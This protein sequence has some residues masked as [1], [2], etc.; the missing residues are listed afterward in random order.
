[1]LSKT[2]K[3][4]VIKDLAEKF[5][6]KKIAIF[7]DFHGISVKKLQVLRRLLKKV[8]TEYKVSKKTLLDRA[9]A[10]SG[11]SLKT[12]TLRGELGVAFSY[13]DEI[14]PAKILAKFGKENETFRVVA[15]ILGT[16]ILTGTE[17]L[18]LAK[19][20]P[21]EI[22]IGQL[23]RAFRTPIRSLTRVLQGNIQ[24]LVVVLN[25]IQGTKSEMRNNKI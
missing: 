13:E 20:P 18:A 7:S 1:M 2:Q 19:L 22:L 25:K 16:R 15:A 17:V 8:D 6:R 23:L 5:E 10:Q 21:K 9:L 3:G 24:N 11:I 4:Q 14:S 12:K